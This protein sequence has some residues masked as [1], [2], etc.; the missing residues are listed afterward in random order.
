M[1]ASPT[2]N[3]IFWSFPPSLIVNVLPPPSILFVTKPP[4]P[5]PG[6]LTVNLSVVEFHVKAASPANPLAPSLYWTFP[7]APPGEVDGNEPERTV[8]PFNTCVVV[9][10]PVAPFTLFTAVPVLIVA[11]DFFICPVEL[12]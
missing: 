1:F 4:A 6:F 10:V 2:H 11:D 7:E 9:T 3:N 5:D 8:E 12:S